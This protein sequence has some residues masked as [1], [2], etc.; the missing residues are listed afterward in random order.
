MLQL[1][2]PFGL[3][4]G[5]GKINLG[6]CRARPGIH[7][8]QFGDELVDCISNGELIAKGTPV[9]VEEIAGNRVVVRKVNP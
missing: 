8:R 6:A 4:L 9:V 3:S 5:R 1:N 2:Q 7:I